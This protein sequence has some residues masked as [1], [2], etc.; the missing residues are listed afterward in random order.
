VFKD[1]NLASQYCPPHPDDESLENKIDIDD[2]FY[3]QGNRELIEK[4]LRIKGW[5][6]NRGDESATTDDATFRVRQQNIIAASSFLSPFAVAKSSTNETA[7][8]TVSSSTT[9]SIENMDVPLL[10]S[11]ST[12]QEYNNVPNPPFI[13]SDGENQS[14]NTI[15]NI[16]NFGGR[17]DENI[18]SIARISEAASI[19]TTIV[20]AD[21]PSSTSTH[22]QQQDSAAGNLN[23]FFFILFIKTI[24]MHLQII[25]VVALHIK[26]P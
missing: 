18:N 17:N 11:S 2:F 5:Y 15:A 8:T 4:E 7:A 13:N 10:I 26:I 16:N 22:M 20:T 9:A 23:T 14:S 3:Y 25:F 6:V 1:L 12:S 24:I 21:I 19:E